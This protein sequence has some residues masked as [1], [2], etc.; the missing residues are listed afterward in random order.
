[1]TRRARIPLLLLAAGALLAACGSGP[2]YD[3]EQLVGDDRLGGDATIT[4]LTINAFGLPNPELSNTERRRFEL[5]DSFFTSPWVQAPASTEAR[6]GLGLQFN[7]NSCAACHVK[8]GRAEPPTDDEDIPGLLLRLS[9]PGPGP[10]GGPNPHPRYGGQLQDQALPDRQAEGAIRI[11]RTLEVGR[12]A[13]GTRYEL[14]RT[15]YEIVDLR[16]GAPAEEPLVSPRIAPQVIGVGLL[17]AI[18]EADVRAAADP[19]DEDGDGISGRVNEVWSPTLGR[20]ALGRF[21][22]KANVATPTA[23]PLPAPSRRSGAA[24]HAAAGRPAG[25]PPR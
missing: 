20:T 19:D 5:G 25:H 11:R 21:G 7:A 8:D 17:E 4:S 23:G 24:R 10:R 22:W 12:Y 13:D 6:D 16:D 2:A 14:E 9:V 15:S 18:P 3:V 1:M